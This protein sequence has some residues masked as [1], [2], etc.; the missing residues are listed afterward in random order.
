MASHRLGINM[1]RK[2]EA[3]LW[4]RIGMAFEKGGNGARVIKL[5]QCGLCRA[6][7]LSGLPAYGQTGER[8]RA[9]D[10]HGARLGDFPRRMIYD[11]D[12]PME[13]AYHRAISAYL[14]AEMV[15]AGCAPSSL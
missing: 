3:A 13:A 5:S 2:K 9:H 12:S 7:Q 14:I 8:V 6:A 4:R 10:S 1:T 15:E 11:G